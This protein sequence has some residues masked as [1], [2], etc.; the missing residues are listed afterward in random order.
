MIVIDSNILLRY[1]LNDDEKQSAQAA[2]LIQGEEKVLVTDAALVETVWTLKGKK[3]QLAKPEIIE[4]VLQLFQETNL[5]F[6]EGQVVWKALSDFKNAK[7][8]KGKEADFADA[9]IV[10]KGRSVIEKQKEVF[11]GSFTFDK[12]AQKLPGAKAPK[13]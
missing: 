12:A 10:C 8:V 1:L 5:Y 3:Y 13:N 2:R 4:T 6:E 11:N 7:P 9:L